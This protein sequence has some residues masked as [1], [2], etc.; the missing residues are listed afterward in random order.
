MNDLQG[1]QKIRPF[2]KQVTIL[3]MYTKRDRDRML[4]GL[5]Y[6]IMYCSP[7]MLLYNRSHKE[8]LSDSILSVFGDGA[9]AHHSHGDPQDVV[10]NHATNGNQVIFC[11]SFWLK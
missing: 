5:L 10:V 6:P 2:R 8:I 4:H 7:W 11:L 1:L 9:H 3:S